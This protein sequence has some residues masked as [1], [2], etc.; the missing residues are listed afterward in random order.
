M[1][2]TAVSLALPGVG[3]QSR[4]LDR[5]PPSQWEVSGLGRCHQACQGGQAPVLALGCS[6]VLLGPAQLWSP[7]GLQTLAVLTP[8]LGSHGVP[9]RESWP[10]PA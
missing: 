9:A 10:V 7:A 5:H 6:P 4:W 2:P 8:E 1:L 3:A